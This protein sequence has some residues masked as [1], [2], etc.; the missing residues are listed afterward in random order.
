MVQWFMF[1][2]CLRL[3]PELRFCDIGFHSL[4]VRFSHV[5]L[6]SFWRHWWRKKRLIRICFMTHGISS[7]KLCNNAFI[8]IHFPFLL[9]QLMNLL[10][11]FLEPN[12]SHS[13]LLAGYFGKVWPI[14]LVVFMTFSQPSSYMYLNHL[15]HAA[16]HAIF[17]GCRMPNDSE[18]SV[19]YELCSSKY[20]YVL[21]KFIL[22]VYS[23]FLPLLG[24]N[25][26]D[27]SCSLARGDS[28]FKSF[29]IF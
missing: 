12:R 11:S 1:L 17:L 10:F 14:M 15:I 18:D 6:M 13:T 20:F 23:S 2:L 16:F 9:L 25:G 7:F 19:A 29:S 22:Q 4:P 24:C 26:G 21:W 5:K 8:D 3:A 28:F 27:G